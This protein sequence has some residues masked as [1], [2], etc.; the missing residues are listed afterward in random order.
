LIVYN[1]LFDPAYELYVYCDSLLS[2]K[3]CLAFLSK[4]G[5]FNNYAQD[6]LALGDTYKH[7]PIIVINS[8]LNLG[9]I[10]S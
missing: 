3:Y 1:N 4:S 5:L 10:L 6:G 2:I 8:L 7:N 9:G